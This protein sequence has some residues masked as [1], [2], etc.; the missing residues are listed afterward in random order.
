MAAKELFLTYKQDIEKIASEIYEKYKQH[1]ADDGVNIIDLTKE[2]TNYNILY[3]E[4]EKDIDDDVH[5]QFKD[6][7]IYIRESDDYELQRYAIAHELGHILLKHDEQKYLRIKKDDLSMFP[8]DMDEIKANLMAIN[9]LMPKEQFLQFYKK[10]NG[11]RQKL[12][13]RFFVSEDLVAMRIN[14]LGL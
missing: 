11:N 10:S 7:H 12:A 1:F 6:K 13:Y 5:G 4:N 14:S 9:I 3:F 2:V 8:D